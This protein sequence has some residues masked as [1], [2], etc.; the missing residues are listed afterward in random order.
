MGLGRQ[1]K[2]EVRRE[3]LS[4]LCIGPEWGCGARLQD[5][6]ET[7]FPQKGAREVLARSRGGGEHQ[8]DTRQP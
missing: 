1:V 7:F 8:F 3:G 2:Q 4:R 6:Q 5:S